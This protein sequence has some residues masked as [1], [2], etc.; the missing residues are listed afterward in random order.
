MCV[1]VLYTCFFLLFKGEDTGVG[2]MT[3]DE[4]VV[5]GGLIGVGGGSDNNLRAENSMHHCCLLQPCRTKMSFLFG[6]L[7]L[8][9]SYISRYCP[10]LVSKFLAG[11]PMSFCW[12]VFAC[13]WFF[14]ASLW[15][16]SGFFP[17]LFSNSP[18]P[19]FQ[20]HL[21]LSWRID[22]IFTFDRILDNRLILC[23][24][25]TLRTFRISLLNNTLITCL[26]VLIISYHV[27][28]Y[29]VRA[30]LERD[31]FITE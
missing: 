9:V 18:T 3:G 27:C 20:F 30:H 21:L 29:S 24:N 13:F 28:F 25:F 14:S 22:S 19:S 1:S 8:H 2:R 12:N 15:A 23:F 11:R 6:S 17:V 7:S 26:G 4:G 16:S 5:G 10:H 31:L